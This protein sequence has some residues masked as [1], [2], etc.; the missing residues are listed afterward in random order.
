MNTQSDIKLTD[1]LERDLIDHELG[2]QSL[3]FMQDVKRAIAA[4]QGVIARLQ[5]QARNAKVAYANG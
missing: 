2:K 5:S 1:Q 3:G 4:V